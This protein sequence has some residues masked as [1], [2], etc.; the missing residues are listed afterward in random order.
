MKWN[1]VP[2][3]G[4]HADF[5]PQDEEQTRLFLALHAKYG[6]VSWERLL[7]GMGLVNIHNFLSR[8]DRPYDETLPAEIAK[9]LAA[10]DPIAAR[11]FAI[12]VDIYGAEAGNM[13]LRLLARGGV[14]LAGGVAAK[15]IDRFTDG[16]FMEAFL[17]K[18]RFQNILAAIPVNLITNAKVG[19]LGAAEMAMRVGRS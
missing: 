16:R 2:S 12:F 18:G 6:H 10:G 11:T 9:A 5:A 1:V 17:R 8:Q 4:G 15:N 7:S 13:A 14:Y 19:L 3:E